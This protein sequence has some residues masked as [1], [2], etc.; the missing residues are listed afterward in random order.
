M[1]THKS[2]L[3]HHLRSAL[4]RPAV[5]AGACTGVFVPIAISDN[6]V[7]EIVANQGFLIS[8]GVAPVYARSIGITKQV[9]L[10]VTVARYC[11][12]RI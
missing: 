7:L 2:N 10:F 9:A 8:P 1:P 11:A 3:L 12:V 5:T 6:R 4:G